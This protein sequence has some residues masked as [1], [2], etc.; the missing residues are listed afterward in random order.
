MS[1]DFNER[2]K[3]YAAMLP[4]LKKQYGEQTLAKRAKNN[5]KLPS[6][7]IPC[8]LCGKKYGSPFAKKIEGIIVEPKHKPYCP[9]CQGQLD[10]GWCAVV[11]M[12]GK[13][14]SWFVGKDMPEQFR[15]QVVPVGY[16]EYEK[17]LQHYKAQDAQS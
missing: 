12:D 15:G 13:R 10:S 6:A 1:D 9:A 14:F 8:A 4:A 16:A 17:I 7:A 5:G 11:T 3:R 2:L